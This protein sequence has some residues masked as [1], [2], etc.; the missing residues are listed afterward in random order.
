M[1]TTKEYIL[2]CEKAEEIQ[3]NWIPFF[4][5]FYVNAEHTTTKGR[6]RT[7]GIVRYFRNEII[8]GICEIGCN[9]KKSKIDKLWLPK[10]NQLQ[11]MCATDNDIDF[12]L[13]EIIEAPNN[14]MK[15]YINPYYVGKMPEVYAT[16]TM[17]QLWLMIYMHEKYKKFWNGKNWVKEKGIKQC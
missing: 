13:E 1:D 7:L 6:K 11:E 2:M 15:M 17:E 5:D 10:Q 9:D 8:D 12:S 16:L 3:N 14:Y 4:G